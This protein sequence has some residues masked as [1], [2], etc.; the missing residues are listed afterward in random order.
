MSHV[1]R[2]RGMTVAEFRR[3]KGG[4]PLVCLTAYTTPMARLLDPI[5][6]LLLVGDSLG[7][8]VYGLP[9]TVPVTLEMMIAHGA[10]VVRGA[11]QCAGDRRPAVRQLPGEPGA[12]VPH[13]RPGHGRD[14]LRRREAR[15]RRGDG[16]DHRLPGRARRAGVRPCRAAAAV[17]ALPMAAT[18]RAAGPRRRRTG[19]SPTRAPWPTPARSPWWSRAWSSR[20]RSGSP[21]P[22]RCRR[23]ASAPRPPATARSWSATTRWACSPTSSPKFVKHYADLAGTIEAAAQTFADDVRARRFPGPEHVYRAGPAPGASEPP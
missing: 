2:T 15:G 22:C 19:S 20:W 6:D 23:S 13:R 17:G 21:R 4:Q 5:C 8:V 16:R 11:S 7:M 18:V 9:S 1:S 3:R 14:R 12:G 10:A